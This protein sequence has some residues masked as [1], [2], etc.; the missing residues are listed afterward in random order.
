MLARESFQ[1]CSSKGRCRPFPPC[2]ATRSSALSR[3]RC[4]AGTTAFT[5]CWEVARQFGSPSPSPF[6]KTNKQKTT[7]V[8]VDLT[9]LGY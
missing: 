1:A 4:G 9:R 7:K 6:K 3:C 5:K 2:L 8:Y